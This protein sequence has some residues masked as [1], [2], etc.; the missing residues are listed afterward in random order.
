M[1]K[2]K[3]FP[4]VLIA[5]A[6][7]TASCV[8]NTV[9]PQVEAI[10]GQQVEWMKAKT[11]TE[12]A[13]AAMK[14][15]EV[16]Y[17]QALTDAKT[18][19][20]A[21]N[22]AINSN[23]LKLRDLNYQKQKAENDLNVKDA[24]N[25]LALADM[26]L[27][28][29]LANLAQS[30]VNNASNEATTYYQR[31]ADQ[32]SQLSNLYTLK[33]NKENAIAAAKSAL[34]TG[35]NVTDAAKK[36]T[37]ASIDAQNATLASQQAR[38]D[39]FNAGLS[40]PT[41]IQ[42]SISNLLKANTDL[43]SSLDKVNS[44]SKTA[45]TAMNTASQAQYKAENVISQMKVLNDQL[46]ILL[47]N[48]ANTN[49]EAVLA[50]FKV[51]LD[52]A[53]AVTNQEKSNYDSKLAAQNAAQSARD[54]AQGVYDLAISATNIANNNN[55]QSPSSDNQT[56]YNNAKA[57]SD[58]AQLT[59]TSASN[60][61]YTASSNFSIANNS[62]TTAKNKQIT[63]QSNYDNYAKYKNVDYATAKYQVESQITALTSAYND[64]IANRLKY[65]QAAIDAQIAYNTIYD[66]A[67]SIQQAIYQNRL[68]LDNLSSSLS[69][70]SNLKAYVVNLTSEIEITQQRIRT[71]TVTLN[72]YANSS[73]TAQEL[74]D[75][76]T[77]ELAVITNQI[78]VT[79]KQA[80][81]WK[82]LLDKTFTV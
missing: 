72:S 75:N 42:T 13:L 50:S 41:T 31:Y 39:I 45:L 29:S 6:F 80:A 56:K 18:K 4:V 58:A 59:L 62:Y 14:N 49:G 53:I 68:T 33:V 77:K 43:Q 28:L 10:R 27:K 71:L 66:K 5:I 2:M 69:S 70:L 79:E 55:I 25:Q 38:L 54:V 1:K 16:A 19:E 40:D 15:A 32:A 47:N 20:T 82:G 36:S 57:I 81:Y 8:D 64:A 78:T 24:Q 9:S 12:L 7:F 37:Q 30:L 65:A 23:D 26:Q 22:E 35:G 3:L 74:I 11:T 52:N 76:M 61:L 73:A 60:N 17:Q 67:S 63:A 46:T 51:P 48:T 34:A 44:D 21:Y